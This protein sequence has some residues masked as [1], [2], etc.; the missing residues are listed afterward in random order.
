M[1]LSFSSQDAHAMSI[2]V[3]ADKPSYSYGDTYTISGKVNPV[4][5]NQIVSIVILSPNYPHPSSLSATPNSDGNYSYTL[6]LTIKDVSSGN[7]TVIAQ[8]GISKNQTTFSYNGPPCGKQ[9]DYWHDGV[10]SAPASNPRVVDSFGNAITGPVKSGQQIQVTS[11]LANGKNCAQTFAYIVQ[12]QD[13]NG[14]T[15][16]LSW[17]TGTLLAGQSLN[18]AQSWTPTT[19]GVYTVQIFTWQS[20]DNPNALAPP[21]TTTISV[22]DNA[23]LTQSSHTVSEISPKLVTGPTAIN[24]PLEQ[25]KSGIAAND[26]KCDNGLLLVIKSEDNSPACVRSESV[27]KLIQLGWA[28][29]D[30]KSYHVYYPGLPPPI[31]DTR[32]AKV[33]SGTQEAQSIVGYYVGLPH[34]LPPG[35]S[36]QTILVD[37]SS[38]FVKILASNFPLTQNTTSVE[39]M[40]KGGIMIYMEPITSEFNQTSWIAGWLKQT[41]GSSEIK[42]NGYNGV[43]NDITT[44]KRFDEEIDLPAEI[45]VF[46]DNALVEISAFLHP[47]ELTKI[48]EG[49][50]AK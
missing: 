28:M 21:L 34:Y 4:I 3:H 50:L 2:T 11:D 8:Y 32:I 18:P 35:Y 26:V 7:F 30:K 40:E 13:L 27:Q 17:I 14:A 6:P 42:I 10:H 49:M 29:K 39:F 36:M 15:F 22:E 46:P 23:N 47:N 25:L 33:V 12:I 44:G 5:P 45:V 38:K 20:L 31:I 16:S 37:G 43:I 19:A 24:S 1:A 41:N 48:A 9:N